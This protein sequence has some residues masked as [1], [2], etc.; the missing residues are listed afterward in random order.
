MD[1]AEYALMDAAEERMWW[2]RALHARLLDAL[3]PARG[4]L[5]DAGCGTGG[6]LAKLA[7]TR[8]DLATTGLDYHLPAARRAADKAGSPALVGTVNAL[9]FAAGAFNVVVSADVLG[10]GGV[11]PDAALAEFRRVLSPGGMLVLNL[12]AHAWLMSAHDRRVNNARRFAR[13]GARAALEAAGFQ[14]VRLRFWNSLLLPLMVVQRKVLRTRTDDRSDVAHF[15]PWQDRILFG[16]MAIERR[17]PLPW[18]VGG[19]LLAVAT[20]RD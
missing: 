9:P 12:P 3:A 18:P 6:L 14:S 8:P 2:Y 1:P 17:L 10:S 16:V 11:S 13:A 19:S 20:R 15:P 5:L 4:R 7:A